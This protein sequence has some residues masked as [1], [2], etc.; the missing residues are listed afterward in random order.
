MQVR[1]MRKPVLASILTDVE[2]ALS[3]R[4]ETFYHRSLRAGFGQSEEQKR[5]TTCDAIIGD[6]D[7][8]LAI[9]PKTY[10]ID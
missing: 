7:Q 4:M 6:D 8:I 2:Q 3:F 10:D 1:Y 5:F 9:V